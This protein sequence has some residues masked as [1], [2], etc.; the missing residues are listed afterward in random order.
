MAKKNSS[1]PFEEFDRRTGYK[2]G[3]NGESSQDTQ[4]DPYSSFDN[5]V[6]YVNKQKKVTVANNAIAK[7]LAVTSV[8]PT[9]VKNAS[10]KTSCKVFTND[11]STSNQT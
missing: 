4:G 2:N 11:T 5:Y 6:D 3:T 10:M 1:N 9:L 7:G 8:A